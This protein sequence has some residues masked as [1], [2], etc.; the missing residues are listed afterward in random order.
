MTSDNG[1]APNVPVYY[2]ADKSDWES[3][4]CRVPTEDL[5]L[6]DEAAA[7]LNL[8]RA[9]FIHQ[10]IVERAREVVSGKAS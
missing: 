10:A 5:T 2:G 3:I 6:I 4:G 7:A 8:K 1:S 9:H